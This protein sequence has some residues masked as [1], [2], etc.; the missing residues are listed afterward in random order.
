MK[1]IS[2]ACVGLLSVYL[3]LS[4]CSKENGGGGTTNVDCS[5]V[6]N[7]AFATDVNPIFQTVC[8]AAGCHANGSSNGPGAL[9][10]WSAISANKNQIRAAVSSGLM[11]QGSALS[12]SQK[13][14]IICWIDSG[15]PNN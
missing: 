5:T 4:G 2:L 9:T 1:K 14:S 8:A 10:T 11:P 12:T 13:N 15:A 3:V 7:K 6:T